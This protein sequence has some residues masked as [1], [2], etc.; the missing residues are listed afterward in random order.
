MAGRA[1]LAGWVTEVASFTELVAHVFA[2]STRLVRYGALVEVRDA[3]RGASY[4]AVV[5]DVSESLSIASID[6]SAVTDIAKQLLARQA[7]YMPLEKILDSLLGSGI[8]KNYGLQVVRLR[9]LGRLA[10]G[11]RG[12]TLLPPDEPPRP[13]SLVVEPD[14]ALLQT[15]LGSGVGP[16]GLVLGSLVYSPGVQA[17]IDPERLTT[18]MA[19]LGQT[20]S[21][22][23]ETVKRLVA[24]YAWR[25][26]LFSTAGGVVVIDVA[27]EYTGYPYRPTGPGAPTPL[28]DAVLE[29][30]R[31]PRAAKLR[32]SHGPLWVEEARKTILVPYDLFTLPLRGGTRGEQ[33]YAATLHRLLEDLSQRY[34]GRR[35]AGLLYARHHVYSIH[36]GSGKAAPIGRGEAAKLAA[37]AELL[38]AAIPLPD[39]LPVEAIVELSR[40]HSAYIDTVVVEAADSLGLLEADTVSA[41]SALAL[42]LEAAHR[43]AQRAAGLRKA[44]AA[45]A[46]SKNMRTLFSRILGDIAE[47]G[48]APREAAKE[49]LE[50]LG[51]RGYESRLRALLG[52]IALPALLASPE[53]DPYSPDTL[54]EALRDESL[55]PGTPWRRFLEDGVEAAAR[56]LLGYDAATRAS[57]VRGLR[58]V[59]RLVSPWLDPG[60]YTLLA[61]RAAEGFTVIQLAEPSRGDTSLATA[62]LLDSLF[63]IHQRRYS[64]Q[65]RTLIV[66]EEAHN[67]APASENTP[68]KRPLL[69]IA[70]EGR[71]WGLSLLLVTQRPGFLDEGVLS[72]AA[73]LAALRITNPTDL[74][75]IK[76]SMESISQDLADR[77][78]DLEPGQAV[79]AGPAVPERRI[80]LLVKIDRLQPATAGGTR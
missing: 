72:Q 43:Q 29:P 13:A 59:A 74:A 17:V 30:R 61:E 76:R 73:T 75:T 14:A 12:A 27:G 37:E 40:S 42:I 56:T 67:L 8:V 49:L 20:G 5:S 66:A 11:P 45:E 22:K 21:G 35:V 70:R 28:L 52:L 23:S 78:P 58:R 9:L 32:E 19:V 4:L 50:G 51:L 77:L 2:P 53:A 46:A 10:K 55:I 68:T 69:R 15:L 62:M 25:K 63:Q 31:F 39:M 18:H 44:A 57:I 33:H 6:P 7:S 41:V 1:G 47:G 71:K 54:R 36:S 60:H 38:V 34:P 26:K 3:S 64:P 24:E 65:R 16:R 80:P 79:V 48:K